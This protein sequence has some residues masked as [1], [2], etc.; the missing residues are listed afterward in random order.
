MYQKCLVQVTHRVGTQTLNIGMLR[1]VFDHCATTT[2]NNWLISIGSQ[3]KLMIT[4]ENEK[5]II[6][7]V[8]FESI[9][10]KC[11]K[12]KSKIIKD[13]FKVS[14]ANVIKVFSL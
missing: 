5:F 2:G 12:F 6:K 1:Q 11:S 4:L 9:N 3:N 7:K 14:W 13:I 8:Y 10:F